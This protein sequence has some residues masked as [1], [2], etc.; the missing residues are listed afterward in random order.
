[1]R[2]Y[3]LY[4]RIAKK[5]DVHY[6]TMQF[7]GMLKHF[8]HEGMK[9]HCLCRAPK[10]LYVKGKRNIL[11]ALRFSIVLLFALL[12]YRFDAIDSNEFP[13]LPNLVLKLY[14]WLHPNT[15]FVSTWHEWWSF[16]YWR[17]Y[18]GFIRGCVGYLLQWLAL[19]SVDRVVAVSNYTA[20][21]LRAKFGDSKQVCIVWNGVNYDQI[22][23]AR[24]E[25]K[26]KSNTIIF[27]G[28]L[29][30]EKRVDDLICIFRRIRELCNDVS[31][32]II[33]DG[34]ERKRL[35]ALSKG[36]P[37]R[38]L[39]VIPDHIRV[40]REIASASVYVSMSEREGFNLSALEACE[41]G[42]PTF[43]RL[44]C[45][46]HPNLRRI[47]KNVVLDIYHVLRSQPNPS[48]PSGKFSWDLLAIKMERSLSNQ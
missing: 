11:P 2:Y 22:Q 43:V 19:R 28:R 31:L 21:Q 30:P 6:F 17:N 40:L 18:L 36:L 13:Y 12:R 46:E 41:L 5:H 47:G 45:F 7:P 23:K 14:R 48:P 35:E 1:M 20:D 37:V 16:R 9:V 44:V 15:L 39:G 3:E 38:F 8:V 32:I 27:T 34:P 24:R 33:G 4:R 42:L 26:T 10:N 25:A 29:I